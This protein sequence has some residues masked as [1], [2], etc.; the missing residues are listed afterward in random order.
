MAAENPLPATTPDAAGDFT[1]HDFTK[2]RPPTPGCEKFMAVALY[3]VLIAQ[4]C[5]GMMT[6]AGANSAFPG[7]DLEDQKQCPEGMSCENEFFCFQCFD[8]DLLKER[9]A[10]REGARMLESAPLRQL[11]FG[12]MSLWTFLAE[13]AGIVGGVFAGMIVV[14]AGWLFCFRKCAKAMVWGM[15]LVD[16]AL[17]CYAEQFVVAAIFAVVCGVF[18]NGINVAAIIMQEATKALQ[19]NPSLWVNCTLI[20]AVY[21]LY[22]VFFI[23]ACAASGSTYQ[24]TGPELGCTL[25]IVEQPVD[26]YVVSFVFISAFLANAKTIVTASTISHWFFPSA[27][28]EGAE[29][30]VKIEGNAGTTGMKWAFLDMAGANAI[31]AV[32]TT[33][34]DAIRRQAT[35]KCL[36]VATA[37]V[38]YCLWKCFENCI[39][40]FARFALIG[41]T[42]SGKGFFD[43]AKWSFDVI[44]KH[45]G[46]GIITGSVASNVMTVGTYILSTAFG[47]IAMFAANEAMGIEEPVISGG[48]LQGFTVAMVYFI[49]MPFLCLILIALVIGGMGMGADATAIVFAIFIGC[50]GHLFFKFVSEFVLNTTDVIF[51]CFCLERCRGKGQYERFQDLYGTIKN[52]IADG[53]VASSIEVGV[54]VAGQAQNTEQ[55][56]QGGA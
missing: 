38:V 40:Q 50:I 44:S 37:G 26:F 22:V 12:D 35:N 30:A 13:N 34:V 39:K 24:V 49:S 9:D 55:A 27:G 53:T 3:G 21:V 48:A 15:A 29:G 36:C 45:L 17:L 31:S 41:G 32:I 10:C 46:Q 23:S 33:I 52:H 18:R 47:L 7:G 8:N 43:A 6:I 54:P 1:I 19:D 42:I 11:Q 56:G 25:E 51:M 2:P 28:G 16:I 4:F 14:A 5:L 20:Q